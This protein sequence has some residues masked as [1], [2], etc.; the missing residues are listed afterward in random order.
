MKARDIM[1]MGATMVRPDT[2]IE[3]AARVMLEHHISGLPVVDAQGKLLGIVTE[4]DLLRREEIGTERRR[5]RWLEVWLS[6]K[7]LAQEYAQE[8]GRKVEHVMSRG[9]ASVG[10]DTP[11]SE[12]VDLME[13]RGVK[14]LPVVSDGKVIG[15]VSRPNLLLALSRHMGE[16]APSVVSDLAIRKSIMDEVESKAWRPSATIDIVV[17][18]GVVD[19]NGTVTDESVRSALR[20]AAENTPGTVRVVDN[21]RVVSLPAGYM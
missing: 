11:L 20:I 7:R 10:P 15:I 4:R 17:R 5:P 9:V 19:L 13:M 18:N 2:T 3:H 12:I 21:L 6:A 8:H 1:T 16:I 14:R